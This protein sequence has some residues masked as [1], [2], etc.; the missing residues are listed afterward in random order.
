MLTHSRPEHCMQHEQRV[1]EITKNDIT[2]PETDHTA[3]GRFYWLTL[4]KGYV[5]GSE[6]WY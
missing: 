6:S 3:R 2:R 4:T 1:A 5:M